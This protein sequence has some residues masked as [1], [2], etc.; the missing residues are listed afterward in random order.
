MKTRQFSLRLP[1]D[2]HDSLTKL[3]K[4]KYTNASTLIRDAV[5]EKLEAD[6][7]SDLYRKKSG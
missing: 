1:T 2:I 4:A 7:K 3:A 6:P 5:V